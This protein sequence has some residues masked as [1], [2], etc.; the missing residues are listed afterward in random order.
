MNFP[1]SPQRHATV[2]SPNLLDRALDGADAVIN[3]AGPFATTAG[4]VI[5][6]ALRAGIPYV[7]VA[8]EIDAIVV[9][10]GQVAN[11]PFYAAMGVTLDGDKDVLGFWAGTGGEG[12]KFS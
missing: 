4:P 2:D 3:T 11:R 12:A 9:R 5:E 7:D 8:T 6:A 10:D 1:G